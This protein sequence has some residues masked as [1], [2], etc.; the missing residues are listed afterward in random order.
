MY[1][2]RHACSFTGPRPDK[3][4]WGYD[5]NGQDCLRLKNRIYDMV[6]AAY[7]S[8]MRH[9]ICG[10]AEGCDMYFAEAVIT[11][12]DE[13]PGITLEAA[14]PCEGQSLNWSASQRKRYD[15]LVHQCDEETILQQQYTPECMLKRNKYMVDNSSLL[16]AV[17]GGTGGGTL[18]TINYAIKAGVKVVT[19]RP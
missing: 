6:E 9:Y 8:G 5:E 12:R 1:G 16:I 14:I 3:L 11:L 4:P 19:I 2:L 10:M 15:Y 17:Y 7:S 13:Y 18:Y